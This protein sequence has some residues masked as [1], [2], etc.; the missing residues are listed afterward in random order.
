MVILEDLIKTIK[1]K[2]NIVDIIA[3][4]VELKTIDDKIYYGKCLFCGKETFIVNKEEQT[5]G[6]YDC[7]MAGDIISFFVDYKKWNILKTIKYLS[8]TI[9]IKI[10]DEEIKESLGKDEYKPTL[11][12]INKEAAKFYYKLLRKKIGYKGMNYYKR[13]RKLTEDTMYKFGLGYAPYGR[14]LLYDHLKEKG[15]S[16]EQLENSGLITKYDDGEICD[17]FRN[18]V[19]VP[20]MDVNGKVIA[21]GGRVLTDVKPKYINSQETVVFD[22]GKTLF[23][24]QYAKDSERDGFILCEGYMDVIS[25]HQAGFDNAIASLGTALTNKHAIAIKKY[26]DKVYLAYDMDMAGREATQRNIPILRSVGIEPLVVNMSPYKDPDEFIQNL[27]IEEF[28]KRLKNAISANEFLISYYK[29]KIKIMSE[30]DQSDEN[31]ED[32]LKQ[33]I[34][35]IICDDIYNESQL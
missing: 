15:Y 33:K 29:D 11:N 3:K 10:S 16:D 34:A 5:Y 14:H 19:M 28:E 13:N 4:E 7:G 26:R 35:K 17:K 31:E 18:R 24:L 23:A 27:G 25:M 20:I 12:E 21:F 1:E 9:N 2:L 6:C 32:Y 22:K 30:D 8:E